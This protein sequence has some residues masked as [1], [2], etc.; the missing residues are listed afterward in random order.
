MEVVGGREGESSVREVKLCDWK[1]N[2]VPE[3]FLFFRHM[4][5]LGES[6]E[7]VNTSCEKPERQQ[8]R[9]L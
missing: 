3:V 1:V 8:S 2:L 4:T 7:A 6:Q 5:E 9:T